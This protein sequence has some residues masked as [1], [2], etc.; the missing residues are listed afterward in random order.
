MRERKL[1]KVDKKR[2][3]GWQPL[4]FMFC[5]LLKILVEVN[6]VN[7]VY[8]ITEFGQYNLILSCIVNCQ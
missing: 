8:I 2:R 3:G 1:D 5:I 4:N 6:L 7:H